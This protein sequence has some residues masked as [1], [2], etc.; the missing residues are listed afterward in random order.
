MVEA[1]I[2]RNAKKGEGNMKI[3]LKITMLL[4]L[5]IAMM[6]TI[7]ACFGT[8][9][10]AQNETTPQATTPEATTP[11][12]TTPE[13]TTPETTTPEA[14]TPEA[15]TPE[16]TT[17]EAT[18]PEATTPEATTPEATTPEATTPEDTTP[19]EST[20]DVNEDEAY[21]DIP[22][23]KPRGYMSREYGL[24]NS[25]FYLKLKFY[26][27]WERR[28]D[29]E[30]GC[31][32]WRGDAEIGR[33][34][35]G[36]AQDAADWNTVYRK[37]AAPAILNVTEYL[38]RCGTGETLR[39]R[40]RFCYRYTECGEERLITLT[41]NYGEA[42]TYVQNQLRDNALFIEHHTDP[43]YGALSHLQDKP[44]VVLGNSFIGT[45]RIDYIYNEIAT[46]SGK[47]P[48]MDAQS[49][50]YASISTYA[51]DSALLAR[52]ANG[53]WSAVFLCG[54]YGRDDTSVGIIKNACNK[55][56]TQLII[57]PAH[58]E[59]D[60]MLNTSTA[61]HPE[62]LKINWKREIDL[63]IKEGRSKWDFCINDAHFHSTEL[64]GY[65]GAMMIWRAIWGE[66]P[67]VTLTSGVIDQE[68]ADAILG[69]YLESPTFE[70]ADTSKVMFLE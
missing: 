35:A 37:D 61:P 12:A 55:S 47:M 19:E 62:L 40:H 59:S 29:G 16:A 68:W 15:T 2:N 41:L 27:D 70:L 5:I 58:N 45:S 6:L 67:D 25:S 4:C 22:I 14:T 38:E 30:G 11:E 20:P 31:S 69:E 8:P 13:A 24:K 52:I 7:A 1:Q 42:D 66:M 49:R 56:N 23:Q 9:N 28:D 34:I 46:S 36:E 32:L 43:M 51:N 17:P 50:G 3:T 21:L 48:M 33:I 18:T 63:L 54:F 65:V 60:A 53:E 39:F 26:L 10:H 44:I 57:F 64:A